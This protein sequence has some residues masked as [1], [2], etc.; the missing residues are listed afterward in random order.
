MPV[1]GVMRRQTFCEWVNGEVLG[2]H[3]VKGHG[4]NRQG[5]KVLESY[6]RREHNS[7]LHL[8]PIYFDK[9]PE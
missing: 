6:R 4:G 9:I 2:G 8:I 3:Q 5:M 1:A 7:Q